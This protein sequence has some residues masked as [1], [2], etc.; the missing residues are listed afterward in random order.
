MDIFD[1]TKTKQPLTLTMNT[2]KTITLSAAF[3]AY[4]SAVRVQTQAQ[5]RAQAM[6]I[7][8]DIGSWT[9]GAANDIADWTENAYQDVSSW[10]VNAFSD[11]GDAFVDAANWTEGAFTDAYDWASDGDN[12]E[13]LGKTT[14]GA[15]VTGF[16]GDWEGGW[17]LFTNSDMY[18]GDTYDDI[19]AA[20]KKQE[21]YEKMM[22][23]QA[24]FCATN[25]PKVGEPMPGS[26]YTTTSEFNYQLYVNRVNY[27]AIYGAFGNI[28]DPNH[29]M[30]DPRDCEAVD[31]LNP[32]Y[33]EN[34]FGAC[35]KCAQYLFEN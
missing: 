12:W 16:S 29:V 9:V 8:D 3:V 13:A 22:Q 35:S 19:E 31:C 5:A 26:R 27:R 15:A 7:F 28:E 11:V 17:D 33:G 21:E 25:E 10:T 2:T 6:D 14:F 34:E 30:I 1:G 24:E 18:Y 32:C 20:K 23:Q 4:A